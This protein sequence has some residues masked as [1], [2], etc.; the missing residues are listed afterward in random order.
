MVFR[1]AV[2]ILGFVLW[3]S[4]LPAGAHT[5]WQKASAAS[6][7]TLHMQS[8]G[9]EPPNTPQGVLR[10]TG[11]MTMKEV[12]QKFGQPKKILPAVGNPPITR[13]IYGKYTVY[14][15]YKYVIHSVVH[16]KR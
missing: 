6:G 1:R 7:D 13:W 5:L 16:H 11:G 10:P 8:V 3:A 9:V 12:R 2:V 4:A 15:E 14:F